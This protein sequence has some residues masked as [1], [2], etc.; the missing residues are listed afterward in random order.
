ML[1]ADCPTPVFVSEIRVSSLMMWGFA[2]RQERATF[3]S[4]NGG[5]RLSIVMDLSYCVVPDPRLRRFFVGVNGPVDLMAVSL[6]TAFA[7]SAETVS[8]DSQSREH[9]V[10]DCLGAS[11]LHNCENAVRM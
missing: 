1:A 10:H 6:G 3:G 8:Q 7:A 4:V 11:S 5:V 9:A 2:G